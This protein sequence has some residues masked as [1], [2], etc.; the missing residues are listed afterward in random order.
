MLLNDYKVVV[1]PQDGSIRITLTVAAS[2]QVFRTACTTSN[3]KMDS[4]TIEKW[5]LGEF[6]KMGVE[7]PTRQPDAK[8][9]K[10]K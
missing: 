5:I 1:T 8:L 4:S 6:N 2:G 9:R 3:D 10:S 7:V